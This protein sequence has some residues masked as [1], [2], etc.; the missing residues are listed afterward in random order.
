MKKYAYLDIETTGLSWADCELTVVGMAVQSGTE[1]MDVT[2]LVGDEVTEAGVMEALEG[3]DELYTYNGGRFDLPFIKNRLGLDLKKHFKH[4]DL[5]RVCWKHDLKGG[6]KRVEE[7]LGIERSVK[8]VDGW[9]A[10]QLWWR[11]VNNDDRAALQKLLAYN[12]EDVLNL[13]VLREMLGVE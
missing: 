5:M 6:L 7:R 11:Y 10:V 12:L 3:V 8:D 2:Q 4:T 13:G 9:V 1:A